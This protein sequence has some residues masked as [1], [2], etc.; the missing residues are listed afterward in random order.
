MISQSAEQTKI[1]WDFQSQSRGPQGNQ[2]V[3]KDDEREMKEKQGGWTRRI[4]HEVTMREQP[5]GHIWTRASQGK[6]HAGKG[7]HHG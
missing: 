4:L 7:P 1:G 2:R 3:E 5:C 6:T